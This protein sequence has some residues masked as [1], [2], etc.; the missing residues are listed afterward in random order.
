[1]STQENQEQVHVSIADRVKELEGQ[2]KELNL[3]LQKSRSQVVEDER[4]L[5]ACLQQLMPLQNAYLGGIIQNLNTQL[6]AK[7][8]PPKLESIKEEPEEEQEPEEEEPEHVEEPKKES[9]PLPQ[10][11]VPQVRSRRNNVAP[12]Q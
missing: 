4:A 3:K 2:Y 11:P 10:P 6:N 1:M 8:A 5:L 9:T 12:S 7:K